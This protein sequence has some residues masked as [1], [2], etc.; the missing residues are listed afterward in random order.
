MQ[1]PEDDTLSRLRRFDPK[2]T[3]LLLIDTQNY[4]WNDKVAERHP[5]F[6]AEL[7]QTVMASPRSK[8]GQVL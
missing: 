2:R 4:V 3:G 7:R 8:Y 1:R 6:D 5:Y